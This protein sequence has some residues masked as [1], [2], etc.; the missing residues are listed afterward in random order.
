MEFCDVSPPS[1]E[2]AKEENQD[3][4]A[5]PSQIQV[6]EVVSALKPQKT[7]RAT[8]ALAVGETTSKQDVPQEK[9]PQP[10]KGKPAEPT[11]PK[12]EPCIWR[13]TNYKVYTLKGHNDIILDVDCSD[14]YVL[15]AR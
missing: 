6:A 7:S 2:T 13:D 1:L 9:M 12:K 5:V 15:S 14:G 4:P 8:Q 11:K 3:K 10:T